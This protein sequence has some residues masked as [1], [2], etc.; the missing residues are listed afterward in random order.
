MEK[1]D[2]DLTFLYFQ[3]QTEGGLVLAGKK[4]NP[5]CLL[6]LPA[7]PKGQLNERDMALI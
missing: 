3:V 7:F 6:P 4:E 2:K 5:C 1:Y